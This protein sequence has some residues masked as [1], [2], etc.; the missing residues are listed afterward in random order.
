NH[1]VFH[2]PGVIHALHS[3][4]EG[5]AL[6]KNRWGINAPKVRRDKSF[7]KIFHLLS[8]ARF[9]PLAKNWLGKDSW[10]FI[11]KKAAAGREARI[12]TRKNSENLFF[13]FQ[14]KYKK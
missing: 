5:L 4:F 11:G 14:K 13:Q 7:G 3:P 10:L 2:E 8:D 9:I 1:F 6:G 12:A